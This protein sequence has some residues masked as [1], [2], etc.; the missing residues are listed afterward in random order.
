MDE[1]TRTLHAAI[2]AAATG[3]RQALYVARWLLDGL[4]ERIDLSSTQA[5]DSSSPT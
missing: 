3:D 1:Y 5:P 4:R 2:D